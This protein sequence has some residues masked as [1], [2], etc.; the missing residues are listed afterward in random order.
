MLKMP[1][2]RDDKKIKSAFYIFFNLLSEWAGMFLSLPC[3]KGYD[4]NKWY[5]DLNAIYLPI[6][7]NN[8]YGFKNPIWW[9]KYI[10]EFTLKGCIFAE[11]VAIIV[12]MM[13]IANDRQYITGREYGTARFATPA[14]ICKRLKSKKTP[15]KYIYKEILNKKRLIGKPYNYEYRVNTLDRRISQNIYISINSKETDINNHEMIIGGSGAGKSFYFLRP[16]LMQLNG[17]YIITDPKGELAS[18]MGQFFEDRGYEVKVLNLINEAGMKKSVR[19]NPLKYIRT[20]QDVV[21]L[22]TNIMQNTSSSDNKGSDPFFENAAAMLLQA[23]IFYVITEYKDEPEKQNFREIMRLLSLAEFSVDPRTGNKKENELDKKF[24]RLEEKEEQRIRREKREGKIPKQKSLA[25]D[26]YNSIMRSAADTARSIVISLDSHL[27]NL[28]IDALLDLLSE[29]EINIPDLGM[30]VNLDGKTKTALFLCVPDADM[31]FNFVAGMLYTQTFQELFYQGDTF[32]KES[33]GGLPIQVSF[34]FDEFAN[35]ALPQNFEK[36]LA[37]MRS[38]NMSAL[39]ILQNIAQL[40]ALYEKQWENIRGNCD[41]FIY[42]GG[43]E[44]TTFKYISDD[45][46][47]GTFNKKT[48]GRTKGRNGSSS[49]NNDVIGRL[50]MKPDEVRKLNR[51]KCIVMIKGLDPVIDFK[52][53]TLKHPF[54]QVIKDSVYEYDRVC[55]SKVGMYIASSNCIKLIEKAERDEGKRKILDISMEDLEK[56]PSEALDMCSVDNVYETIKEEMYSLAMEKEY[57]KQ[58]ELPISDK[59]FA[60]MNEEEQNAVLLLKGAGYEEKEIKQLLVI[61]NSGREKDIEKLMKMFPV[62]ADNNS[63]LE[64]ITKQINEREKTNEKV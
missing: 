55:H 24:K 41:V 43:N 58:K 49:E 10:N 56:L 54:F 11:M 12:T 13:L 44:Q 8:W 38:R 4:F 6:L 35:I 50:L 21:S 57:D 59:E 46:G 60:N 23:L 34:C 42:L 15:E 25:I 62:G 36:I 19:Y 1:L 31:S 26:K 18:S 3:Q 22:A 20:E 29:D 7:R 30:G 64:I 2:R 39:I 63:R 47:E 51:R 33:G 53:N 14:E 61:I 28:H 37:T 17:T 48:T 27:S 5:R 52:T 16:F 45:I 40:K 32:C 9:L